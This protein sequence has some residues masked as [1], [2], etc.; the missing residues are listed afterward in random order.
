MWR[1]P[2]RGECEEWITL[3]QQ[4]ERK[5]CDRRLW[6]V[7]SIAVVFLL[8]SMA[9]ILPD[10]EPSAIRLTAHGDKLFL[11]PASETTR[12]ETEAISVPDP[13]LSPFFFAPVPVNRAEKSLLM[14][15]PGIG[16]GLAER[17]IAFREVHGPMKNMGDFS[18]IPGIGSKRMKILQGKICFD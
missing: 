4:P 11:V 9:R 18:R 5:E 13:G 16:E 6:V 7:W 8:I 14:T 15:L 17:I 2:A 10:R 12:P 3:M 1:H